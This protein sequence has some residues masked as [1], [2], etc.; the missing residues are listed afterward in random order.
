MDVKENIQLQ[1]INGPK[2]KKATEQIHKAVQW[3]ARVGNAYGD[4]K[5]NDRRINMDW[6][7]REKYFY[8]YPFANHTLRLAFRPSNF[9]WQLLKDDFTVID[10]FCGWNRTDEDVWEW[11]RINLAKR[12]INTDLLHYGVPYD[13]PYEFDMGKRAVYSQIDDVT[14]SAF[15]KLRT[16]G[17]FM[18]QSALLFSGFSEWEDNIRTCP[19]HLDT[20]CSIPVKPGKKKGASQTVSLGLAIPDQMVNQYHLYVSSGINNSVLNHNELPDLPAGGYWVSQE[21]WNGAV[22]PMNKLMEQHAVLPDK[23]ILF[24]IAA[25]ETLTG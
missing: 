10:T 17:M 4:V 7:Y 8:G 2:I 19:I 1:S 12:A 15:L 5:G 20:G 16:L 24:M 25:I 9:T 18:I 21:G 14:L 3:I 6:N 22:L 13:L 23:G 11:L